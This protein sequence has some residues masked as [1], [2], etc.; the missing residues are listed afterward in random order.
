MG[1]SFGYNRNEDIED[2]KSAKELIHLLIETVSKGGNLLLDIGPTADGRIPVIMQERLMQIGDWLQANGAAIYGTRP[3]L[4]AEP[5]EQ[6]RFTATKDAIFAICLER[7]AE[8]LAIN[9]TRKIEGSPEVRMLGSDE[10][11]R[12]EADGS[13]LTLKIPETCRPTQAA[14]VFQIM[15]IPTGVAD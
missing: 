2:Y 15:G 7:P 4:D 10:S 12:C 13:T 1:A 6:I 5:H 8:T 3:F 14:Y 9:L 11:V